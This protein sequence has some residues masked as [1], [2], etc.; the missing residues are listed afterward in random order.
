M[1]FVLTKLFQLHY[2]PPLYWRRA[3]TGVLVAQKN[4]NRL[5]SGMQCKWKCTKSHLGFIWMWDTWNYTLE[6]KN[7]KKLTA[8]IVKC[9]EIA[10]VW[11]SLAERQKPVTVPR[12]WWHFHITESSSSSA[13]CSMLWFRENRSQVWEK[14]STRTCR[15]MYC[16]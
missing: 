11:V 13:A 16:I 14:N 6:E 9:T 10:S 15:H 4:P 2:Y 1:F 8:V 12:L 3:E 5:W 7:K